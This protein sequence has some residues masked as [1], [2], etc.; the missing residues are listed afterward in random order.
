MCHMC[1]VAQL[2]TD[3]LKVFE[4]FDHGTYLLTSNPSASA[5]HSEHILDFDAKHAVRFFVHEH[6]VAVP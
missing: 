2:I 6:L 4:M 5:W 1:N 3:F